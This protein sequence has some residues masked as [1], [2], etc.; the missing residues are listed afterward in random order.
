MRT[1]QALRMALMTAMWLLLW[2][3]SSTHRIRT[4]RPAAAFP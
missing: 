4:T 2:K 3:T 1:P